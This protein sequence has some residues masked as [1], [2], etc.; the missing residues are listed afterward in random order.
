MAIEK[1]NILTFVNT[2]L[3]ENYSNTDLDDQI[4]MVLDELSKRDMLV[5]TATPSLVNGD[6]TIDYPTGYRAMIALTL[7]LTTSGSAQ[8]PLL[9]LKGGHEEYRQ[10]LHNDN[11]TGITRWFSKFNSKFWLWRPIN[12]AAT[13]LIEYIKDHPQD[14]DTIEF[15]ETKYKNVIYSGACYYTALTRKKKSYLEIWTPKWLYDL[16]QAELEVVH[17]ARFVEGN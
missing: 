9:P 6:T 10:L 13:V 5:G 15:D 3:Q 1:A 7:T 12:Q 4:Q 17:P 16:G 14:V 8:F 11:T 2:A